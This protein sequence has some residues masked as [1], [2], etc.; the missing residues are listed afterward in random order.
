M[1]RALGQ[2]P[3]T[4]QN[5]AILAVY[6]AVRGLLKIHAMKIEIT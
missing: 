1:R 2:L 4:R 3:K 5:P 6:V